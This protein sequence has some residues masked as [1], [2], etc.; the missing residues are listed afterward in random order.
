MAEYLRFRVHLVAS[1]CS[2]QEMGKIL[3]LY[4]SKTGNTR[5]MADLV[6]EGSRRIPGMDVRIKA[7][8]EAILG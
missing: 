4:F 7:I 3:V 5:T 1:I 2:T 6:A 8:D